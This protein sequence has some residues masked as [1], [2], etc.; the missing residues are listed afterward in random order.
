MI[1]EIGDIMNG[2]SQTLQFLRHLFIFRASPDLTRSPE[3]LSM[4]QP[5]QKHE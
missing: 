2:D 3:K 4:M 1:T 5:P